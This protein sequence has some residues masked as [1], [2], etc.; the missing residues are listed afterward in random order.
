M[1]RHLFNLPQVSAVVCFKCRRDMDK[2]EKLTT[3]LDEFKKLGMVTHQ[4]QEL[5]LTNENVHT[6]VQVEHE[7]QKRCHYDSP[8]TKDSP[9]QKKLITSNSPA[10]PVARQQLKLHSIKS[11]FQFSDELFS[12][13]Q[14]TSRI[15]VSKLDLN[16]YISL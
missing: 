9:L 12:H 15:E 13:Q 8:S 14:C 10:P 11:P 5:L 2:F 6:K 4:K 1:E 3:S 7:R 16:C